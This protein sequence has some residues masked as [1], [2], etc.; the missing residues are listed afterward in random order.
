[1]PLSSPLS[2]RS[3]KH[4]RAIQVEAF[5]RD[6]GLWELDARISDVKTEDVRLAS[7]VRS[8]GVPLHLLWLRVT[9]DQQFTIVA[10]ETVSDA[11]PY[12][13]FCNTINH[14]YQAL[15]G[16]NL[17]QGFRHGLRDRLSGINGCTHLT[18]LA[19][20]LPT[21]AV[22]TFASEWFETGDTSNSLNASGIV[23]S[24]KKPLQIDGCHALR[25]DGAAVAKYYPRWAKKS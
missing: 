5:A 4:T 7:G 15:V 20:V 25:S 8:A 19:Q 23:S 24:P 11:M 6:D 12:P 9:F 14:G 1:M 16:L 2:R 3:L 10:A 21:V 13:G 17:L 18:E 22:Q